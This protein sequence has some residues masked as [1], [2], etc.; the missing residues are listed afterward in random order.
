MKNSVYLFNKTSGHVA[1]KQLLPVERG[2]PG[3][4][5]GRVERPRRRVRGR[6]CLLH[7]RHG[8]H[9][10]APGWRRA[11][12]GGHHQWLD[13]GISEDPTGWWGLTVG[14]RHIEPVFAL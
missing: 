11:E 10:R 12:Q 7:P 4:G 1:F 6:P 2:L 9:R 13:K 3:P 8:R 5:P 14:A